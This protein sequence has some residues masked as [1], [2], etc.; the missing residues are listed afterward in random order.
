MTMPT[1]QCRMQVYE[2]QH[3]LATKATNKPEHRFTKLYDLLTY[4]PLME[5]AFDKLMTNVGSRTAGIDGTDKRTAQK[6]RDSIIAELRA[7][8]KTGTYAF[9]PKGTW[10]FGYA[11]EGAVVQ[12]HGVGPFQIHWH[13]GAKTLNDSDASSTFRLKRGDRVASP[14]GAGRVVEG[15][16][17]GSLIQYEIEKSNGE[18]FM[19]HEHE[20]QAE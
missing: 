1:E 7:E 18:R 8:L 16:A 19:A 14:R 13:D 4:E 3:R 9:A 17:S 2:L 11:S 20:L 6:N 10:M 12:V 15:Y 5:W